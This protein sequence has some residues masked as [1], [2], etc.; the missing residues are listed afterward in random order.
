MSRQHCRTREMASPYFTSRRGSLGEEVEPTW[1]ER[2]NE[3]ARKTFLE[4]QRGL[5]REPLRL[6]TF[7]LVDRGGAA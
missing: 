6:P 7:G 3:Y 2:A 5:T 1:L 4:E